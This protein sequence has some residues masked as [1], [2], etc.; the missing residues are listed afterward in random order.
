PRGGADQVLPRQPGRPARPPA[1]VRARGPRLLDGTAHGRGRIRPR[2]APVRGGQDRELHEGRE[3]D[4]APALAVARVRRP[5]LM[6]A[7][8]R[9]PAPAAHPRPP[10]RMLPIDA[11]I[12]V[13]VILLRFARAVEQELTWP[14]VERQRGPGR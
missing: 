8:G 12:T 11:R 10:R 14:T 4:A 9:A 6:M 1:G 5:G 13:L 7:A 3:Q 2:A